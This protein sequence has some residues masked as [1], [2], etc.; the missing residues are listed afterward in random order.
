M[1][2]HVGASP[3]GRR[4]AGPAGGGDGRAR[5]WRSAALALLAVLAACGRQEPAAIRVQDMRL[6]LLPTGGM[7]AVYFTLVNEGGPD[8]LMGVIADPPVL[9][10]VHESRHEKGMARMI[11][12]T[13]VPVPA[14]DRLRFAPGGLHVMLSRIPQTPPSVL[15]LTL[16]FDRH[17]DIMVTIPLS[18]PD[19]GGGDGR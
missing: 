9:A 1:A 6:R 7:G 10:S 13:S 3:C 12:R 4:M 15:R 14:H 18:P 11:A 16:R 5:M 17:P 2:E 8:R 19:G